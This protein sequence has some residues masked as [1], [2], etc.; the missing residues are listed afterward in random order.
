MRAIGNA[1]GEGQ[2]V[3]A[4]GAHKPQP[5]TGRSRRKRILAAAIGLLFVGVLGLAFGIIIH[6]KKDSKTTTLE[7]PEGSTARPPL[8]VAPFDEATAREHQAQSAK[9]LHAPVVQSNSIGMKLVLIPPGEFEMG[10]SKELIK[11]EMRL[12]G[13]DNYDEKWYRN[14]LPG[15]G[16]QHHVR[17]TKPF[18]LGATPV[19]QGEYERVTGSNPSSSL[20]LPPSVNPLSQSTSV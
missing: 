4:A 7:V 16:P 11:G 2:G 19:T 9:Y 6:L 3:R 20:C 1:V 15:E 8:A 18:W 17:I 12:H 5:F 13:G 10:S 14:N